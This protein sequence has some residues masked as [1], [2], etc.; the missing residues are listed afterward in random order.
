MNNFSGHLLRYD[1]EARTALR[2]LDNLPDNAS[3][4][5]FIVDDNDVMVGSL[6]DGDIRRGLLENL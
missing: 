3:R 5:L 6:T 4:T 2:V 1:A